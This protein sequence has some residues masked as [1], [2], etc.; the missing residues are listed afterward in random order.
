MGMVSRDEADA[1]AER[2]TEIPT[3]Q[4]WR[5]PLCENDFTVESRVG[6]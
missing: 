3:A 6:L 2:T 4:L 5:R 1:T